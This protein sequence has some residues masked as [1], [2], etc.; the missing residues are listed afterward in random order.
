MN[1]KILL[2]SALTLCITTAS[3]ASEQGG[4][5]D[6][7]LSTENCWSILRTSEF[8]FYED[9]EREDLYRKACKFYDCGLDFLEKHPK[10]K[11]LLKGILWLA[12]IGAFDSS[13]AKMDEQFEKD[14]E[15]MLRDTPKWGQMS[16]EEVDKEVAE[17]FEDEAI[18]CI[19]E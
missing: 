4:K 2:L 13:L 10:G 3:L 5:D 8:N 1:K 7:K 12:K 9:D 19:L 11:L 16:E 18:R 17:L 6:E 14:F 15:E